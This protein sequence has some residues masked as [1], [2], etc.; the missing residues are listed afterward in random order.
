MSYR[1]LIAK[2]GGE[3]VAKFVHNNTVLFS[4]RAFGTKVEA[5]QAVHA[6]QAQAA[7]AEVKDE[8]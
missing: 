7:A 5:R 6:L 8:E 4:S 2:D 1:F 3:Y